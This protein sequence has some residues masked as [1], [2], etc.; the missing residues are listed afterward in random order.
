M[1]ITVFS[2][3]VV[4]TMH[5]FIKKMK[6]IPAGEVAQFLITKN[7]FQVT[8]CVEKKSDDKYAEI[9]LATIDNSFS[10]TIKAERETLEDD[11]YVMDSR[12]IH[13]EYTNGQATYVFVKKVLVDSTG[14]FYYICHKIDESEVVCKSEAA[15]K[16][17]VEFSHLIVKRYLQ[18]GTV[19]NQQVILKDDTIHCTMQSFGPDSTLIDEVMYVFVNDEEWKATR[20]PASME[21]FQSHRSTI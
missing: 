8:E 6:T 20:V 10:G 2:R 5:E 12:S 7:H 15:L 19:L 1:Q 4:F 21:E 18:D 13:F 11:E 3:E 16:H 14:R 9:D 17:A